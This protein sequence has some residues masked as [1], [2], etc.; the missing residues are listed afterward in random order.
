MIAMITTG[1]IRHANEYKI[2]QPF[3][4]IGRISKHHNGGQKTPA[5]AQYTL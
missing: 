4:V 1:T 2:A 3:R 5:A